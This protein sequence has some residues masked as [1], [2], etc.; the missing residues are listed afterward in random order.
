MAAAAARETVAKG[1]W[2]FFFYGSIEVGWV[3]VADEG[4]GGGGRGQGDPTRMRRPPLGWAVGSL[5]A[6]WAA[7]WAARE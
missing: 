1:I 2:G 4:R 3:A 6:S 7:S 5:S